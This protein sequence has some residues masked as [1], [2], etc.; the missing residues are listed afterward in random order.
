MSPPVGTWAPGLCFQV[1]LLYDF[2]LLVI[3]SSHDPH[4]VMLS[5]L[6]SIQRW[7]CCEANVQ[8]FSKALRDL[9]IFFFLLKRASRLYNMQEPQNWTYPCQQDNH[10]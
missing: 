2:T 3:V 9:A 1:M 7:T 6:R 5:A 10:L 8:D 4:Y